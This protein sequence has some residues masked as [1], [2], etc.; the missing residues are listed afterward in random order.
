MN[1]PRPENYRE[2]TLTKLRIGLETMISEEFLINGDV[3]FVEDFTNRAIRVQIRGYLWS[4][5]VDE[6]GISYPQDWWQAFKDRWF[7]RRMLARWPVIFTNITV[8]T[9]ALYPGFKPAIPDHQFTFKQARSIDHG[10]EPLDF[11]E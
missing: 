4:E 10:I 7:T 1:G 5:E 9:R 11:G 3:N 8:S 2:V 6:T